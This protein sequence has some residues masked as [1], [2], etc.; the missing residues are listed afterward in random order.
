MD[1]K[2]AET[3]IDT[4]AAVGAAFFV[5]P[6]VSATDKAIAE[7]SS[8]RSTLWP[9]FFRS[10]ASYVKT[11]VSSVGR[12]EF[13][14]IWAL[15]AGTYAANNFCCSAEAR[16]GASWPRSKTMMV[17]SC[18]TSLSLWKDSA[19]ARLFGRSTA[20]V[21][22]AAYLTWAVRDVTGMAF[23]FT[24]PPLV[25]PYL[26]QI[27]NSSQRTAEI[28]AQLLLPMAIQPVVSPFHLLGYDV[29]NRPASS[30]AAR[31]D[32]LRSQLAGVIVMRWIRGFPPYCLGAVANK[33]IRNE[34]RDRA[35]AFH[36]RQMFI[37]IYSGSILS[38]K[39]P[40]SG[41]AVVAATPISS[42][43]TAS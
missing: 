31:F 39:D 26:S 18:N 30:L 17:F 41:G 27:A 21:P 11:P 43:G 35:D 42:H 1:W 14:I 3:A 32:V 7:S 10:L 2:V 36:H 34:L 38:A 29:Y 20:N 4:I 13:R 12:P 25:A 40:G 5:A 15:Y 19:F 28:A 33:T 24:A 23:I 6:F 9:S 16:A 37:P 8:G 22:L